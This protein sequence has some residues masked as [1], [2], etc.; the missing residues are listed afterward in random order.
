MSSRMLRMQNKVDQSEH[1]IWA[2]HFWKD[3]EKY[4]TKAAELKKCRN[5]EGKSNK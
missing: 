4:K 3:M 5:Q 2:D 1:D